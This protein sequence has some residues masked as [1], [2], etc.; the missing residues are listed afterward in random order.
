MADSV[1]KVVELVGSSSE[2]WE[3]A[4]ANAI[5]TASQS[6]RDLRI[7]RVEE[8]DVQVEEGRIVAYRVRLK[9]SFKYHMGED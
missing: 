7:A 1:Y 5:E 6:L 4:A 2:S 9:L 3:K 8:Q